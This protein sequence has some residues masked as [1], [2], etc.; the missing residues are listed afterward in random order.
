MDKHIDILKQLLRWKWDEN[1]Y[2]WNNISKRDE[3]ILMKNY[4]Y[5]YLR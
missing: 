4:I 3:T 1:H 2:Q 5:F